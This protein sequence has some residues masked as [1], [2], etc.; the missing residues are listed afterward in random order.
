MNI[1]FI[2]NS[3]LVLFALVGVLVI[4][5]PKD[6]EASWITVKVK[7]HRQTASGGT[8]A[9][10]GVTVSVTS[11][12]PSDHKWWDGSCHDC[13]GQN[14]TATTD[15]SGS[16]K[17]TG[18]ACGNSDCKGVV[19]NGD[20]SPY[21]VKGTTPTMSSSTYDADI[22]YWNSMG[23]NIMGLN[24]NT[25]EKVSGLKNGKT[26]TYS[27]MFYGKRDRLSNHTYSVNAFDP[28]LD[29]LGTTAPSSNPDVARA[30]FSTNITHN[31]YPNSPA[32]T[33][34]YNFN[35]GDGSSSGWTTSKTASH[36]YT[37]NSAGFTTNGPDSITLNVK[38]DVLDPGFTVLGTAH[39]RTSVKTGTVTLSKVP[40]RILCTNNFFDGA[41]S[42]GIIPL[43]V[44][45]GN[46]NPPVLKD[47]W[48]GT[49]PVKY[50]WNFGDG[51][52]AI[53]DSNR[54][55]H[56]YARESISGFS[57]FVFGTIPG[58]TLPS[59]N[60]NSGVNI[61]SQE[62]SDTNFQEVAP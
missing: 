12:A 56:T 20:C 3:L 53:T 1:K 52:T 47:N 43:T 59:Q 4:A 5:C 50:N 18:M 51:E 55:S 41:P 42:V 11:K 23:D 31:Q 39:P 44:Q 19:D 37:W 58:L 24:G 49:T 10:A 16:D 29:C 22:S 60:C 38:V 15:G 8:K 35:Y 17:D 48:C 21:S 9:V 27:F 2:K 28:T 14:L 62:W 36:V 25:S 13:A 30:N 32:H 57:P 26:Y 61:R 34:R 6:A 54:T 33:V 40:R 46:T 7:A 45:F